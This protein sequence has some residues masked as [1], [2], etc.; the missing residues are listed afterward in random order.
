M[1]NGV[2]PG[3]PKR[4]YAR[5]TAPTSTKRVAAVWCVARATWCAC[6]SIVVLLTTGLLAGC[7][8]AQSR[9]ADRLEDGRRVLR[10]R[11]LPDEVAAID[12]HDAAVRQALVEELGVGERD[13]LVVAAI[14]NRDRC[15]D[16]WE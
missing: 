1:T 16:P 13:H 14:D 15:R 6:A 4:R 12:D 9:S 7:G 2:P 5:R 8:P 11:L 3:A 10:R